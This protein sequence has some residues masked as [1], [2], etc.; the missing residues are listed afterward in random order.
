MRETQYN[1]DC[2]QPQSEIIEQREAIQ[3]AQQEHQEVEAMNMNSNDAY[4]STTHQISTEI[5]VAYG[6]IESDHNLLS[7]HDQC[8]Y[9]YI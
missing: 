9:D 4:I 2:Q 8:E 5:N 1:L 6:Q 3:H 7:D